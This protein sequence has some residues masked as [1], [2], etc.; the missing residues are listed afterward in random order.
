MATIKVMS[1]FGTRPEAIKMIPVH[2]ALSKCPYI[3]SSICVTA[4]HRGLLDQVLATFQIVPQYDMDIMYAGQTLSDIT[5]NVLS[6]LY[7]I[8]DES[9]PDL[10]LVHGD[11]TTTFAASLAAFYAKLRVG[12][13]EAGLRSYDKFQPYPEEMNRKLTT[14]LADLHFAPTRDAY[15]KL[16]KEN[17]PTSAIYVT[18]NTAID[19][20]KLTVKSHH[21]FSCKLL[22]EVDHGKRIILMTAHR[23][24]NWGEKLEN[25]CRAVIRI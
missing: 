25:I 11:T 6:G 9:K 7:N 21:D 2:F 18:G 16:A 14:A 15:A 10:L 24:E 13:V 20:M 5:T 19:M 17:V 22:N 23:R 1:V 8:L 12:H 3:E 4:Q